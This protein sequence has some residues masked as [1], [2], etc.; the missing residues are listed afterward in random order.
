MITCPTTHGPLATIGQLRAFFVDS[1]KHAAVLVD[2]SVLVGV[3]ERRDLTTKL[4][5]G[6]SARTIATLAGRTVHATA[7]ADDALEAMRRS[8]RRRLA[9]VGGGGQLL[10]LLSL[11]ARGIGFCSD[12]DVASR[13]A[14]ERAAPG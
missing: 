12:A 9:V 1:H 8:G 3:V 7:S 2:Q 14:R 10:G 4:R 5:D 13:G 11:K 6:A